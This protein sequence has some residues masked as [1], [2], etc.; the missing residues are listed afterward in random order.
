MLLTS[1]HRLLSSPV[2]PSDNNRLLYYTGHGLDHL[3]Q[4]ERGQVS[5][6][7][8]L[9]AHGLGQRA[10]QQQE[11]DRAL[12]AAFDRAA[13]RVGGAAASEAASGQEL[14]L[15]WGTRE[16]WDILPDVEDRTRTSISCRRGSRPR[17]VLWPGTA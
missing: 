2:T 9:T 17:V 14:E 3:L 5:Q 7:Y 12:D 4:A 15:G 13:C 1:A 10:S 11:T 16:A 6:A 8:K